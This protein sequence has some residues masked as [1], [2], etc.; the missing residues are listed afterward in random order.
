MRIRSYL[1][2]GIMFALNKSANEKEAMGKE[3]LKM[4]PLSWFKKCTCRDVPPNCYVSFSAVQG[5]E[6]KF[7]QI[8]SYLSPGTMFAL[9]QGANEKESM[10]KE[11]L[12]M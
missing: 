8:R 2:P 12:K 6:W 1:S 4:Y 5:R 11:S 7:A 3:S 9:N 10:G